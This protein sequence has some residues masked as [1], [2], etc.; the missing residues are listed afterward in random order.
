ME[1]YRFWGVGRRSEAKGG[2]VEDGGCRGRGARPKGNGLLLGLK[3]IVHN[4]YVDRSNESHR[5][6]EAV[7]QLIESRRV[8]SIDR[9]IAGA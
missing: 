1:K 4:G 9:S 3:R 5:L 8:R 2:R 6:V 7:C